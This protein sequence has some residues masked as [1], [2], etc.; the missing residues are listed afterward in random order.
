MTAVILFNYTDGVG[1]NGFIKASWIMSGGVEVSKCITF[2]F[3]LILFVAAPHL[4]R[5]DTWSKAR[6]PIKGKVA[7][8]PRLEPC[9]SMLFIGSLGAM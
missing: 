6:R 9:W 2:T 7:N 1:N 5:L 8:E 3:G 4:T